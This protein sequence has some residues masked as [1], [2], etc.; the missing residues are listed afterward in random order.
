MRQKIICTW[1]LMGA[2]PHAP[3]PQGDRE[4]ERGDGREG[5]TL[6]PPSLHLIFTVLSNLLFPFL[7]ASFH[8]GLWLNGCPFPSCL[9]LQSIPSH[10]RGESED[11]NYLGA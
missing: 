3:V 4:R 1:N 8:K 10:A 5:I 6:P 7:P 9:K 11:Y 2:I